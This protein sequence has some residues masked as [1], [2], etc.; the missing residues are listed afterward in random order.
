MVYSRSQDESGGRGR[1][2]EYV[3]SHCKGTTHN[4]TGRQSLS[5]KATWKVMKSEKSL[6]QDVNEK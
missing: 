2:V 6:S 3:L 1:D 5:S 4:G